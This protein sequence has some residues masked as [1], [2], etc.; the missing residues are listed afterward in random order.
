M[1]EFRL[2]Q[3]RKR[4][5]TMRKAPMTVILLVPAILFMCGCGKKEKKN[6]AAVADVKAQS[7]AVSE[8]RDAAVID[9]VLLYSSEDTASATGTSLSPLEI[10]KAGPEGKT[11]TEILSGGTGSKSFI[12]SGHLTFNQAD[13]EAAAA[14]A[15]ALKEPDFQT[16]TSAF[17]VIANNPKFD[18]SVF[19]AKIPA[20]PVMPET[21]EVPETSKEAPPD[22][23]GTNMAE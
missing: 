14:I 21:S 20:Q 1:S 11:W 2:Q 17:E 7:A 3:N 22:S 12:K 16:R 19:L 5:I 10:V 15:A 4:E 13:I 9:S 23:A 8:S 18:G 6:E